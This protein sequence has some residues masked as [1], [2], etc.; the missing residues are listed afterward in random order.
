MNEVLKERL[1][2]VDWRASRT[3]LVWIW[4]SLEAREARVYDRGWVGVGSVEEA[5]VEGDAY[6]GSP[7]YRICL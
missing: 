4:A 5:M 3:M 7:K 1:G 2:K 6:T